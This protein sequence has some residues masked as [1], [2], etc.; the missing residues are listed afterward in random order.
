VDALVLP[1]DPV[2]FDLLQFNGNA[3]PAS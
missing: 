3:P 2:Y 1:Y